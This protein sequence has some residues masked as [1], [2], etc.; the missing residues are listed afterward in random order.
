[1]ILSEEL[2]TKVAEF[3]EDY[4]ENGDTNLNKIGYGSFRNVY[5][6]D[7]NYVIK[8]DKAYYPRGTN[9]SNKSEYSAYLR[10][11]GNKAK[12]ILVPGTD[13]EFLIMERV[14]DIVDDV[15][16]LHTITDKLDYFKVPAWVYRC[17]DRVQCGLTKDGRFVRYD[18]QAVRTWRRD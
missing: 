13:G 10:N 7:E 8:H 15:D 2:K 5:E 14:Y 12:C 4:K 3:L 11:P 17:I 1:M 9:R 6:L 18:Y 16:T